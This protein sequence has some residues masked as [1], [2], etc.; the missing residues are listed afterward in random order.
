MAQDIPDSVETEIDAT[1]SRP[2]LLLEVYLDAGTLRYVNNYQTLVFPTGGNSYTGKAFTLTNK[3]ESV[4]SQIIRSTLLIDNVASDMSAFNA[5]ESFAGKQIII[6][7]VFRNNLSGSTLY[8]EV[9][10]GYMEEP[11]SINKQQMSIPIVYGKELQRKALQFVYQPLCN[12]TFGDTKCNYDGLANLS[13]STMAVTSTSDS[14]STNTL[15][16]STLTESD[17]YWNFGR[18]EI[19]ISGVTYYRKIKSFSAASDMLTLDVPLHISI[20][21]ST[22]YTVYKGCPKTWEACQS[23]GTYG[24]SGDNKANFGSFI[25]IGQSEPK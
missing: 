12:N 23:G 17:D 22:P 20:S 15:V 11:K 10:N 24:P 13:S 9:F 1:Q 14:G 2:S 6:K 8:R 16:D 7:K 5:V 3:K 19:G 21:G 4:E 25:H 18:I